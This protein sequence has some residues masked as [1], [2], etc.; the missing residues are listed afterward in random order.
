MNKL[1]TI[2]NQSRDNFH[3]KDQN[4]PAMFLIFRRK[5]QVCSKADLYQ[6]ISV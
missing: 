3:Y 1:S 2:S 6:L 5:V 4:K